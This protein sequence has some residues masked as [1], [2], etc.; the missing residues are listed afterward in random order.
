MSA[1]SEGILIAVCLLTWTEI[2]SSQRFQINRKASE[3][4]FTIPS[5]KCGKNDCRVLYKARKDSKNCKCVCDSTFSFYKEL[6]WT[7]IGNAKARKLFG[8]AQKTIFGDEELASRMKYLKSGSEEE[9]LLI[10]NIDCVVNSTS[11]W[12]IDCG[13]R[14]NFLPTHAQRFNITKSDSTEDPLFLKVNLPGKDPLTGRI[15]NLGITCTLPD[16]TTQHFCL[17]FKL[18]GET[19]CPVIVPETT[20][21][22]STM[23]DAAVTIT[24]TVT[25]STQLESTTSPPPS[26]VLAGPSSAADRKGNDGTSRLSVGLIAGIGCC[27]IFIFIVGFLLYRWKYKRKQADYS[28]PVLR[29]Q[30]GQ[31]SQPNFQSGEQNA[32]YATISSGGSTLYASNYKVP[33]G[34]A[35]NTILSAVRIPIANTDSTEAQYESISNESLQIDAPFGA[36][37]GPVYNIVE[38]RSTETSGGPYEYVPTTDYHRV[39]PLGGMAQPVYNILEP[40][41]AD[42]SNGSFECVPIEEHPKKAQPGELEPPVYN[43][44]EPPGTDGPYEYVPTE[45]YQ[46]KTPLGVFEQR[47]YSF[48]E[49][50]R[51]KHTYD[52][53]DCGPDKNI[54]TTPLSLE[55]SVYSLIEDINPGNYQGETQDS[56]Y[57]VLRKPLSDGAESVD[58]HGVGDHQDQLYNVLHRG[59]SS[60]GNRH[61]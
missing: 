25:E 2:C 56:V 19:E 55:Q 14:T 50:L 39:K 42:T 44:L 45:E 12:Y 58:R 28:H 13:K 48:V 23:T 43:I 51:T 36:E 46:N 33:S 31:T 54:S 35:N 6:N 29:D 37:K 41:S 21:T 17:L 15:V 24:A 3:D 4:Y 18:E 27:L 26:E 59:P 60:A 1:L 30:A 49:P 32:G 10:G 40:L 34:A 20:E 9:L 16:S 22:V 8:C 11:S 38:P 7:C 47:E 61:L 5:S 57:D 53:P 52:K